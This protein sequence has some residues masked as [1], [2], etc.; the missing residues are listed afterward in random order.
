MSTGFHGGKGYR[1]FTPSNLIHLITDVLVF[2]YMCGGSVRFEL[3]QDLRLQEWCQMLEYQ[4]KLYV[5]VGV[6]RKIVRRKSLS[7]WCL[8][9]SV[10]ENVRM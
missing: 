7:G 3:F 8:G 2:G 9:T 4:R 10:Q 1:R 5:L 6:A